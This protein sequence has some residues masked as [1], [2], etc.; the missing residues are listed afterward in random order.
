MVGGED[1]WPEGAVVM[2]W[3]LRVVTRGGSVP[4]HIDQMKG[5]HAVILNEQTGG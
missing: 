5:P 2:V 1:E 3:E 4:T